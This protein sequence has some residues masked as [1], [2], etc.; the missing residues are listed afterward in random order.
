MGKL[1]DDWG[2]VG[3]GTRSVIEERAR[4]RVGW[5]KRDH[6]ASGGCWLRCNGVIDYRIVDGESR[7]GED[8]SRKRSRRPSWLRVSASFTQLII[9]EFSKIFF[10]FSRL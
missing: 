9:I 8:F 10:S 3:G 2:R 4:P 6:K 7:R 5:G 1:V